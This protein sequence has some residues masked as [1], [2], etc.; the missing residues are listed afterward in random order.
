MSPTQSI[1]MP[2]DSENDPTLYQVVLNHEEQYSI[3]PTDQPIPAGWRAEGKSGDKASC[4]AHIKIVWT[5]MTPASLRR[6]R[7]VAS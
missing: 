5:D 3:W 6:A 2:S 4:L 7:D 1:H